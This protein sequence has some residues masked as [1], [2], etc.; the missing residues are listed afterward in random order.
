M[1]GEKSKTNITPAKGRPMLYWVGKKP[2]NY[3]KSF[4]AQLVEIFDPT[5]TRKILEAPTYEKVKDNWQ[6][7]PY[8]LF[9]CSRKKRRFSQRKL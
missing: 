6:N 5:N 8:S 3:V 9:R 1:K 4:P 2:S 7:F